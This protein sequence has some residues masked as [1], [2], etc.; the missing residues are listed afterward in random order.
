MDKLTITGT[1]ENSSEIIN[2]G[3]VYYNELTGI[4]TYEFNP[5]IADTYTMQIYIGDIYLDILG[6]NNT[7]VTPFNSD[8]LP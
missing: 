3:S 7:F 4:Q 2:N 5:I 1:G 8:D 6:E